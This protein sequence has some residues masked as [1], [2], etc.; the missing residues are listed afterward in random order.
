MLSP[1]TSCTGI[2]VGTEVGTMGKDIV[3]NGAV[4]STVMTGM[5]RR[6]IITITAMM[7]DGLIALT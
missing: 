3:M 5:I 1:G 4:M 7:T 2:E 6:G